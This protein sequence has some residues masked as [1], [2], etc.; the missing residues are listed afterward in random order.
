MPG[1]PDLARLIELRLELVDAKKALRMHQSRDRPHV[2][3][4]SD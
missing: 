4:P 3:L 1:L 2:Q